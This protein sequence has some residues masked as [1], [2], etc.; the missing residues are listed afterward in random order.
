[1]NRHL[2]AV[3][4][5]GNIK[6]VNICA[7]CKK[8]FMQRWKLNSHIESV[9]SGKMEIK[10]DFDSPDFQPQ[11]SFDM[12]V[13]SISQSNSIMIKSESGEKNQF[14]Q[15]SFNSFDSLNTSEDPMNS[16]DQ[17]QNTLEHSVFSNDH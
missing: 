11:L 4:K 17:S 2:K 5:D 3:H 12:P 14:P 13:Q 16:E 8:K 10:L 15:S 7:F 1:M 6:G 9:H